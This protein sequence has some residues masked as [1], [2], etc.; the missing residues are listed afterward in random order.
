M[1]SRLQNLSGP[2][3][4]A[5]CVNGALP[6]V[7]GGGLPIAALSW[8]FTAP[9]KGFEVRRP[10]F[11]TVPNG[12]PGERRTAISGRERWSRTVSTIS[13]MQVDRSVLAKRESKVS[14]KSNVSAKTRAD[15]P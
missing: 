6:T 12:T 1:A 11:G 2:S 15:V 8:V 9:Q 4:V 3:A 13:D 14:I 10:L 7:I 5:L